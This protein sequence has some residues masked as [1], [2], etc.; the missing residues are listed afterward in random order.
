MRFAAA[1]A[2]VAAGVAAEAAAGVAA[3]GA[4]AG[5]A[6]G[7]ESTRW[8]SVIPLLSRS[9]TGRADGDR[10]PRPRWRGYRA[11]WWLATVPASPPNPVFSTT[12]WQLFHGPTPMPG[13][14][15]QLFLTTT[16]FFAGTLIFTVTVQV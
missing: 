3:A 11:G 5:A 16:R 9:P 1:A 13:P 8:G 7:A 6:G 2:G 15:L 10:A 4:V 14:S 12:R